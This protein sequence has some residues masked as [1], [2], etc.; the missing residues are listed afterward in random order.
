MGVLFGTHSMW[1][2]IWDAVHSKIK[3]DKSLRPVERDQLLHTATV[4]IGSTQG[5]SDGVTEFG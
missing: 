4:G 5:L 1:R 2:P 3:A